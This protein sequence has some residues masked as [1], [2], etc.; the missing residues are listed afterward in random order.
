AL[1]SWIAGLL[2]STGLIAGPSLTCVHVRGSA[3]SGVNFFNTGAAREGR[4]FLPRGARFS[5][6]QKL[7]A[8]ARN[9]DR[10]PVASRGEGGL[11]GGGRLGARPT[12]GGG[13]TLLADVRE[14]VR[15]LE[16]ERL[17]LLDGRL[18][19]LNFVGR[20]GSVVALLVRLTEERDRLG[21]VVVAADR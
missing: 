12:V 10:A 16:L 17:G 5:G 9:R 11:G 8:D 19:G 13:A 20:P 4:S 18:L 2:V 1:E 3:K 7:G 6:S 15:E 21:G 14:E